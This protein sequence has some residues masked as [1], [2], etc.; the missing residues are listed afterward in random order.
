[1][2]CYHFFVF[3]HFKILKKV[4][5]SFSA[6]LQCSVHINNTDI[7]GEILSNVD[8]S[9]YG[10]QQVYII[11]L[12]PSVW[13]TINRKKITGQIWTWS[14]PDKSPY[15]RWDDWQGE[16]NKNKK[17]MLCLSIRFS[18]FQTMCSVT[19]LSLHSLSMLQPTQLLRHCAQQA[20]ICSEGFRSTCWEN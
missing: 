18:T 15:L 1:M 4:S 2:I 5:F 19:Q 13:E 10:Q 3:L 6:T 7:D 17:T 8:L 11:S 9:H 12:V 14:S 20:S 16:S